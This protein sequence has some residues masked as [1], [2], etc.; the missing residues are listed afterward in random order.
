VQGSERSHQLTFGAACSDRVCA[1]E[2][3]VGAVRFSDSEREQVLKD[4]LLRAE[5][6]DANNGI[7]TRAH[8]W[9]ASIAMNQVAGQFD[10]V[11]IEPDIFHI[12]SA[13]FPA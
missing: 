2:L 11:T 3:P 8:P 7:Q 4:R 10:G 12:P 5:R 6:A 9:R 1:H 13:I